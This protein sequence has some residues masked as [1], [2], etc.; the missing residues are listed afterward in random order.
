[1]GLH[2]DSKSSST[3]GY[4]YDGVD[5]VEY[6]REDV[7]LPHYICSLIFCQ[8]NATSS[9][10]KKEA[11]LGRTK[12]IKESDFSDSFIIALQDGLE[13][14]YMKPTEIIRNYKKLNTNKLHKRIER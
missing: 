9:C 11:E 10:S 13:P 3:S 7:S 5:S 6:S 2:N 4:H 8:S 14:E 1:M 12:K